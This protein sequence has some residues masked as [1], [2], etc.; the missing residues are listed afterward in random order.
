MEFQHSIETCQHCRKMRVGSA[1]TRLHSRQGKLDAFD[2]AAKSG[3][4]DVGFDVGGREHNPSVEGHLVAF[5]ADADAS[6]V[7]GGH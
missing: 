5:H 4:H 1:Q 6:F 7:L 2:K 3:Q